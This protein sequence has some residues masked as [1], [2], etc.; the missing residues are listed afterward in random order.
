[1]NAMGS[2]PLSEGDT[3]LNAA[4]KLKGLELQDLADLLGVSRTTAG[5][6]C[7][8]RDHEYFREPR[9]ADVR[10]AILEEFGLTI[11]NFADP[12]EFAPKRKQRQRRKEKA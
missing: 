6:Y 8:P 11:A 4:R 7:N 12:Y 3:R 10:A 5:R 2:I 1:M 9:R